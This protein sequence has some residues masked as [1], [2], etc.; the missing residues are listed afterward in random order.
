MFSRRTHDVLGLEPEVF[1]HDFHR[2]GEPEGA[3]SQDV[4]GG[5][6]ELGP[7]ESRSGFDR[8]PSRDLRRQ[9]A[10]AVF[11]RLLVEDLPRGQ[12]YY[13]GKDPL[14]LEPLV[15]REA[16]RHLASGR[17]QEHIGLPRRRVGQYVP[18][19]SHST[20]RRVLSAIEHRQCL[21]GKHQADRPVL[22]SHDHPPALHH[23]I[24]VRRPQHDHS[25]HGAE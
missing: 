4:T 3:H 17:E 9:H 14:G 25:W 23:F 12:A 15:G 2:R 19:S 18:A 24:G 7:A 16:E 1:R 21:T 11:L 13:P 6:G 5:S 10:I 20:R 8:H 22:D